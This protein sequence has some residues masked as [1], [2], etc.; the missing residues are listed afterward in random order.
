M[1]T[2]CPADIAVILNFMCESQL[3]SHSSA[4]KIHTHKIK[5]NLNQIDGRES[6]IDIH[7]QQIN[8]KKQNAK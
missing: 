3:Y 7:F 8:T 1:D 5:Y 2:F 4:N 6:L